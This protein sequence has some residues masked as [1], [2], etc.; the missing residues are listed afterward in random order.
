MKYAVLKYVIV[1]CVIFI[2]IGIKLASDSSY[3]YCGY[4]IA[5][6]VPFFIVGLGCVIAHIAGKKEDAMKKSDK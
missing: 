4:Y 3:S 5:G 2:I 6:C 1:V